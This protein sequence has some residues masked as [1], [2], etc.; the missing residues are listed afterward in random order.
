MRLIGGIYKGTTLFQPQDKL[1]RPLKDMTKEA[2]FKSSLTTKI[3]RRAKSAY[4]KK[5]FTL[6]KPLIWTKGKKYLT[7]CLVKESKKI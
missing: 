7:P 3:L 2:I 1:T 6:I 4:S 5:L